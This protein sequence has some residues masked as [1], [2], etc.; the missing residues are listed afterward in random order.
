MSRFSSFALRAI[1]A[2]CERIAVSLARL[3]S[4]KL[5]DKRHYG[6]VRKDENPARFAQAEFAKSGS[7]IVSRQ[8]WG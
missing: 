3:I 6:E 8:S 5:I 1:S 7:R 2:V 4:N